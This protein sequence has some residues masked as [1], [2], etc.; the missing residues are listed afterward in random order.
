MTGVQTLVPLMLDHVNAGR[1]SLAALR[2]SDQR[3]S[4]AAV[5]HRLQGADRG[6]LRR[7]LHDRR[8]EAP[9]D[10]HQRMDGL[11]A[12]AGRRMT[13]CSVTGWP[14]GTFVRG[15]RVMWQGELV[16]AVER[17][18]GAVSGDAEGV[19]LE[20]ETS[21]QMQSSSSAKADDPVRC[22]GAAKT[23]SSGILDRP[24]K[25]GDDSLCG[26]ELYCFAIDRK[27]AIA[28]AHG[29][30]STNFATASSP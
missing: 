7:R 25:P 23:R 30:P 2:R 18:A 21:H 6:R 8:S 17:R 5:R 11:E 9:R 1:L 15:R 12:P 3:G 28:D 24:I 4:G 29:R 10:H 22:G 26:R 16:D 14:V 13:A 20:G 27:L 19:S